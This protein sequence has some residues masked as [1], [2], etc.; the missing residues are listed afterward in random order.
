MRTPLAAFAAALLLGAGGAAAQTSGCNL[1]HGE[2]ELLRQRVESPQRARQL[3]VPESVHRGSAHGGLACSECHSGFGRYPH[4]EGS[5]RTATC[6]SCHPDAEGEW[7]EGLHA[8]APEGAVQAACAACHGLHD[9]RAAEDL[10][11]GPGLLELNGRC[12]ECH[13]TAA[14]SP[15]DPHAGEVPCSACHAPH[16]TRAPTDPESRVAVGSQAKT[17]GACHTTV[18]ASWRGDA[19]GRAVLA[20]GQAGDGDALPESLP[21]CIGCHGGHGMAA[22]GA[23][24]FAQASTQACAGCHEDAARTWHGSYHGKAAL[25]GSDVAA[26]CQDCHGAHGIHPS[27][28]PRSMVARANLVDTCAS[29][30]EH[31][32][33]AFVQYDSHPDPLNRARNPWIFWSFVFMNVLLVGVLSVFGLHTLLW[34]VRL[35]IDRRRGGAHAHGGGV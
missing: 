28:D 17:C 31:A 23:S 25:L 10:A 5:V 13:P 15:R 20:A 19:H 30:H 34:W 22:P 21:G 24:D 11:S 7:S 6:A 1:C 33:P 12:V 18:E 8:E 9:V 14:L 32:R 26:T 29:C 35:M 2:M 27:E 3:L 4:P 16:A